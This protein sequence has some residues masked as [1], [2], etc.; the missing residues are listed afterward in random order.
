MSVTPEMFGA[1]PDDPSFDSADA[2]AAAFALGKTVRFGQGT[3]YVGRS[4]SPGREHARAHFD[5]TTIRVIKGAAYAAFTECLGWDG[6]PLLGRNRQ[7]NLP[8]IG[9]AVRVLFDLTGTR[10]SHYS[11]Q[12]ELRGE[13][14]FDGLALL[15]SSN[16]L[17]I[18]GAKAGGGG[19][20]W[21]CNLILSFGTYGMFGTPRFDAPTNEFYPDPFTGTAFARVWIH[22]CPIPLLAGQNTF[23]DSFINVLQLALL[24]GARSFVNGTAVNAGTVFMR[25]NG[26]AQTAVAFDVQ[27]A[28]LTANTLYAENSL[29]V[30][31]IL[32]EGAWI[33]GVLRHGAGSKSNFARQAMVFTDAATAGGVVTAHERCQ[34]SPH[35]QALIK[36][37]ARRAEDA[38]TFVVHQPYPEHRK[39]AFAYDDQSAVVGQTRDSLICH[40]PGGI[41]R[42]RRHKGMLLKYQR[43]AGGT[44]YQ[45]LVDA[46][47]NL[48]LP[49]FEASYGTIA[50]STTSSDAQTLFVDCADTRE[51]GFPVVYTDFRIDAREPHPLMLAA[52]AQSDLG[53]QITVSARNA[54]VTLVHDANCR[55]LGR[56]DQ[57]LT[58]DGN[59]RVLLQC[60]EYWTGA[61]HRSGW[62]QIGA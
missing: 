30:P 18:S 17:L 10:Y 9:T 15:A 38:R 42:Y 49:S 1:R 43:C 32:R 53:R 26:S 3:Y 36:L 6:K 34:D 40:A 48:P 52:P 7:G 56:A 13:S 35:M 62:V 58:R 22:S 54:A 57:T 28:T 51:N 11:G 55:L 31:I 39:A 16:H 23:D 37:G 25:C 14:S 44:P 8:A 50:I 4:V 21:D 5:G 47:R 20:V 60:T 19:S 24:D 45:Q 29:D 46:D 33:E 61:E 12:L 27:E 41:V 2:I 59:E